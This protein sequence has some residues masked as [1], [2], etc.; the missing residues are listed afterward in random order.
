[1]INGRHANTI[2]TNTSAAPPSHNNI[3]RRTPALGAVTG[4]DLE[5]FG[6][7]AVFG[8]KILVG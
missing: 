1:L 4:F 2:T 5:C 7:T 3:V 6:F 8:T